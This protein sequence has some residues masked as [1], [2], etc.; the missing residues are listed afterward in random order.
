MTKKNN[1]NSARRKLIPAVG[2]LV[3]SAM[4]LSSATYAWFSMSKDVSVT[5]MKI[6]ATAEDGLVISDYTKENWATS[7]TV[8]MTTAVTLAP[9]STS[10]VLTAGGTATSAGSADAWVTSKSRYFNQADKNQGEAAKAAGASGYADLTLT[11]SSPASTIAA[12]GT[13]TT[14]E[15]IGKV[16][17]TN[18]VLMKNF[19]IK[20]TGQAAWASNLVIDEVKASI[21]SGTMGDLSKSLRVLV[22]AGTNS[23][24]YA[25]VSG[26]DNACQFKA[27]GTNLT[28]VASTTDSTCSSITSIPITDEAAVNVRMYLYFEGEDQNCTSANISGI[29]P[30]S[31]TVSAKFKTAASGG[32]QQQVAP[33]PVTITGTRT[34]L[35]A[36]GIPAGATD[37]KVD[38][39]ACADAD[40]AAAAIAAINDENDNHTLTYT[41]AS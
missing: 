5:G 16:G 41:P 32:D 38:G 15:G 4:M 6:Q 28:L 17:D 8:P 9:T 35:Q 2:M 40:A 26:Y 14:G 13:F 34:E 27:S 11:Y 19:Y 36:A 1:A 3:A 12:E 37:I 20:A 30:D 24:I 22:V 18:Y 21:D 7:W 29:T 39:T 33:N 10:G 23:F 25:P 31:L